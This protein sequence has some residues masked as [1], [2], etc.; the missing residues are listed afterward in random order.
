MGTGAGLTLRDRP[1]TAVE[2]SAELGV[3]LHNREQFGMV[4]MYQT[5][6]SPRSA[7]SHIWGLR[8]C[9]RNRLLSLQIF[10]K[11][12]MVFYLGG[13]LEM[14]MQYN[15]Q[16]GGGA[17]PVTVIIQRPSFFRRYYANLSSSFGF[18]SC[19]GQGFGIYAEVVQY[20]FFKRSHPVYNFPVSWR[21]GVQ[22]GF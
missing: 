12:P 19:M 11:R 10:T 17:G 21:L 1:Q 6:P 20:M 2:I 3:Y 9:W 7:Y 22:Y 8:F 14:L 5:N 18:H 13:E 16:A 15:N 4:F